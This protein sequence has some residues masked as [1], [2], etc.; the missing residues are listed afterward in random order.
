MTF[1]K[2]HALLFIVFLTGAAS[3]VIEVVALRLL[4]PYYGNTIYAASSVI[5][6]I[7]AALS[8]GY[9]VGGRQADRHPSRRR[10]FGIILAS[11]LAVMLIELLSLTLLPRLGYRLSLTTG[12]L[13]ASVTL[14]FLPAALL[15]TLSPFAIKLES[16]RRPAGQIG[17]VSGGVFF[18]STLGSIAGSL[19]A[20]FLLI[21]FVGVH[22]IIILVGLVLSLL[23]LLPLAAN[24][25]K[26]GAVVGGTTAIV[27]LSLLLLQAANQLPANIVLRH[28]G[29]YERL[30]VMNVQNHDRPARI[31]LQ[32]RTISG[33]SYLD[34]ADDL[35]EY[36]KYAQLATVKSG[37]AQALVLGGG[38]Y[39]VPKTLLRTFPDAKVVVAE[40]EPS[41]PDV[42]R[43][44]FNVPA[45]PRL[46]TVIEDGRRFLHDTPNKYDFIFSDVFASLYS[47]PAHLTTRE[48]LTLLR[49]RL[50]PDGLVV[51]NFIGQLQ[52]EPPSFILSAMRTFQ[53][54]FPES[55]FYAVRNPDSTQTQNIMFVGVNGT[56]PLTIQDSTDPFFSGLPAHRVD[57]AR[58][59][60]AR[61]TLLVDNY[62][63]VEHLAANLLKK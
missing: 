28:D 59:D 1:L 55:E 18:W 13:V 23:G 16:L 21:P 25:L 53:S 7:L 63:P 49:D 10:F 31:L 4:S 2:R 38:A 60:L 52:P 54:V 41:L 19:S 32:D 47:I 12:P 30:T 9:Y 43:E 3:L 57:L 39:T 17:S 50:A 11:G 33:G 36:T 51:A 20:G 22:Q 26:P 56:A 6:V 58:F 45:D 46:T 61:H 48:F 34:G 44:F 40:I 24:G 15:G 35:F 27:A 8:V 14:F 42:S 29:T 62:A 5:G 37:V